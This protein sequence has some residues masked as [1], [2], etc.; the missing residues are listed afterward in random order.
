MA[1]SGELGA[2]PDLLAGLD[3]HEVLLTADALHTQRSH[4][5][6]VRDRGG[7]YLMTV[8]A[9]QPTLLARLRALPWDQ[10]GPAARGTSPRPRPGRDPHDQC[11]EP[12][13]VP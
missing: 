13:P 7:H 10:I 6:H 12:A 4:A 1:K 9:N 2:V 8:K 11:R 3:L 5:R